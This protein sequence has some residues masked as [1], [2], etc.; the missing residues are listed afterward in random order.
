MRCWESSQNSKKINTSKSYSKRKIQNL[1]KFSFN[2]TEGWNFFSMWIFFIIYHNRYAIKFFFTCPVMKSI[3]SQLS[4]V[5]KSV[6]CTNP[7]QHD[8]ISIYFFTELLKYLFVFLCRVI[9]L[10]DIHCRK[11]YLSAYIY[12][13]NLIIACPIIRK[14]HRLPGRLLVFFLQLDRGYSASVILS[15]QEV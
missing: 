4:K 2:F 15:E 6:L 8:D 14:K 7:W 12:R 1:P 9:S 5:S 11:H 3:T 10:Y 13:K